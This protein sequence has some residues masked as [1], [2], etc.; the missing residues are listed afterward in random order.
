[1]CEAIEFIR[2]KQSLLQRAALI[3]QQEAAYDA[4]TAFAEVARN[5]LL[6]ANNNNNVVSNESDSSITDDEGIWSEAQHILRSLTATNNNNKIEDGSAS[7]SSFPPA[8]ITSHNNNN[9][10]YGAR[11]PSHPLIQT[12]MVQRVPSKDYVALPVNDLQEE[13]QFISTLPSTVFG[14]GQVRVYS[15]YTT[16]KLIL[17]KLSNTID[18][19]TIS[20]CSTLF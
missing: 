3:M 4:A 2:A 1:M 14:K 6:L 11:N 7:T 20:L 12:S 17:C 5:E 19:V 10:Q 13:T 18:C 9:T 8:V 16:S 15:I